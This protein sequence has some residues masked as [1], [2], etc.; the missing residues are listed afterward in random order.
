MA[1][2]ESY[3]MSD[4]KVQLI[5][6][7]H[8]RDIVKFGDF[9]LKSGIKSPIYFDIRSVIAYPS[10]LKKV[11]DIMLQ[12]VE[13]VKFTQ[14]CGVPYTALPIGTL[15]ASKLEIPMIMKRKE[16][17]AYGTKK[18]I[19]GVF[20]QGETCLIVEDLVTSGMSVFETVGPLKEAGMKVTD[21][22]VLLDREQGGRTNIENRGLQLHSA[23]TVTEILNVLVKKGKITESKAKEV[24]QWIKDN[25]VEIQPV[26]E[27]KKEVKALSFIERSERTNNYWS[28]KLFRI[29]ESKKTN[30]CC[31]ADVKDIPDLLELARNVGPHICLLKTHMDLVH[32]ESLEQLKYCIREL[33]MIAGKYEFLIFEDRKF[34]DIGSTMVSQFTG[35][36]YKISNWT[37]ITN[38]HTVSGKGVIAGFKTARDEHMV[39]GGV[40]VGLLLLAEMSC[41]GCLITPDYTQKTVKMAEDNLDVVM[42]FISQQKLSDCPGLIHMT[43]GVNLEIKGDDLGQQYN[44]PDY[45]IREKGTDVIIVGRGIYQA[46]KED[47]AAKAKLYR[48]QAWAAYQARLGK[49]EEGI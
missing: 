4:E 36:V 46:E 6:A 13:E 41:E 1:A 16:K 14:L 40:G 18:L 30:L 37:D 44:T 29:M 38:A 11:A 7:L 23:L 39:N 43:P 19:E 20:K 48:D 33:R 45:V 17:K 42:G 15:M 31:S 28:Q 25:Q 21:V 12:Q 10:I 32:A 35:G 9:T 3:D 34:A 27:E 2:A 22:V 26:E 24:Q 5:L 49:V 8:K 47:Q